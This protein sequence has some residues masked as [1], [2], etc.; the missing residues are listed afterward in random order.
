MTPGEAASGTGNPNE[1]HDDHGQ[2]LAG[3]GL[4]GGDGGRGGSIHALA[5]RNLNTL[6]DFFKRTLQP[7]GH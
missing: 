5:D 6:I 1:K 7:G 2:V 3:P 4:D